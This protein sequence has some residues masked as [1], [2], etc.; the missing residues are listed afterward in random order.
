MEICLAALEIDEPAFEETDYNPDEIAETARMEKLS[1]Y[2]AVGQWVD[3]K[4]SR[5]ERKEG[6]SFFSTRKS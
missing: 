5:S 6:E 3:K 1:P 2:K 4:I